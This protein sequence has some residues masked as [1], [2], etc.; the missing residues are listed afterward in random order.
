M[1]PI[2]GVMMAIGVSLFSSNAHAEI[3]SAATMK[4]VQSKIEGVRQ[5]KKPEDVL[6][7]FDIDMTL[8]QPDH[9]AAYYPALKNYRDIYK[10]IIENLTAEQRDILNTLLVQIIPQKLVEKETPQ[11]MKNLQRHGF[12][13]IAFTATLTG[14]FSS[15][16]DKTICLRS[17]QLQQQ[18]FD[19][20]TSFR[21]IVQCI[22]FTEFSQYAGSYPMFYEGVLSSN[23]E[24]SATKGQSLVAFLKYVGPNFQKKTGKPGYYPKVIVLVDDRM[25]NLVDVE[26]KLK[27]YDPSIQFIGIEYQGAFEIAPQAVSKED[28]QKFWED[29]VIKAKAE[30]Y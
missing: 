6:A 4:D 5:D 12:K 17:D 16:K 10:S 21:D 11:I 29:L 28:F 14:T 9:M 30:V 3:T 13:V 19:F 7:A 8:I 25:K 2:L 22:I 27:E 26:E 23:G 15:C 1:Y 20:T 24:R 18:E